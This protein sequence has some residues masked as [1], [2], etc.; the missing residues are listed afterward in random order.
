M[1]RACLAAVP[2]LSMLS[3]LAACALNADMPPAAIPAATGGPAAAGGASVARE[4]ACIAPPRAQPASFRHRSNRIAK[5]LGEPRFRG[6]D[7]I[8]MEDDSSQVL[9][10]KLAYTAADKDVGGEEVHIYACF[11]NG[12]RHLGDAETDRNGRFE[13]ALISGIRLPVGMRDLYA[14]V[15]GHG[16]GVRFLAYVAPRGTTAIVVDVDGTLT[17]SE[18]AILNTVVFGDDI[19]H[20]PYAPRA[21]ELAAAGRPIVYLT[22]RGDQYTEVTRRWLA[23]HGFPRGPL[24]LARDAITKPG[25]KTVAFKTGVLR[26]L[27]IPVVAGIGNRA[28]D[29][30]AYAN[31]G[32]A[33]GRILINLPEFEGEV[34]SQLS[35]GRATAFDDYREVPALLARSGP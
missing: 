34:R 2:L 4:G 8:A 29:I 22:S 1:H 18:E 6:I 15:P 33:P 16:G 7:L 20:Q 23:V 3:L 24:R 10:G 9:G 19:A 21:L 25:P 30:A 14:Y 31:A 11:P 32:L 5:S 35:A 26:S 17:E 28:S 13:L 12:W 27:R